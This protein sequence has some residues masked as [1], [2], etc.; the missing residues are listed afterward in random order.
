[1]KIPRWSS[2][3]V[4]SGLLWIAIR[5][6]V[7][8]S[9]PQYYC[10]CLEKE[11]QMESFPLFRDLY[12][13]PLQKSMMPAKTLTEYYEKCDHR[14][15]SLW[16]FPSHL[17]CPFCFLFLAGVLIGW[18]AP[19]FSS[20]LGAGAAGG[21]VGEKRS[22]SPSMDLKGPAGENFR[23]LVEETKNGRE[24]LEEIQ[25]GSKKEDK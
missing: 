12:V 1:M 23:G 25:Y 20:C 11:A 8:N 2:E 14:F 15:S 9:K 17:R 7:L 16:R 13:K 21:E 22:V 19:P 10:I 5:Q 18:L 6:R 3:S 4:Q 24:K